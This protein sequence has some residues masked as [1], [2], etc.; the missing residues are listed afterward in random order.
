MY[1]SA[2]KARLLNIFFREPWGEFHQRELARRAKVPIQNAHQYLGAFVEAGWLIRR[3]VSR[4]SFF[5]PQWESGELLKAFEL[6]ELEHREAF[7]KRN[8]SIARL[9]VK[10][11]GTLVHASQWHIQLVML[12][13]S[14]ARGM[15]TSKSDI[16]VLAVASHP[17][18]PMEKA[19]REAKTATQSVLELNPVFTD[20]ESAIAGFRERRTFHQEVW[21]DRVVLYNEGLFWRIVREG[22]R[23]AG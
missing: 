16:D 3:D 10:A 8:K 14:V 18:S 22:L 9:L 21:G 19:F 20:I 2:G 5:R 23:S 12:F 11:T 17:W 1:L 13:G 15:W 6:F 7:L 4:M